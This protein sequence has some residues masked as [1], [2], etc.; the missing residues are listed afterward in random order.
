MPLIPLEDNFADVINKAQAGRKITDERLAAVAAVS[1]EDLL[2]VKGGKPMVP[3]LRRVARH[4]R[5]NPNALEDLANKAWYPKVPIFPRGFSMF[6]QPYGET[7]VNS[8]LAWDTRS[9]LAAAFDTGV[10]SSEMIDF[11][12][13]ENLRLEYIF[14]THTHGDHVGGLAA[15]EAATKAQVWSH[16]KEPTAIEGAR[17]FTDGAYFHIDKVSIKALHTP[18]HSEGLSTFFVNGLGLPLAIVGDALFAASMGGSET[19]FEMQRR[20]VIEKIMKL[21]RDS[22]FAPGHGPLTTLVQEKEHNPFFA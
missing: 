8:Y 3:V 1:M 4:L 13:S 22:V 21:P 16:E 7:S 15:L 12:K 19:H 2:A 11:I 14:I 17:T 9:R 20:S 6:N 18:G 10:D 5:L